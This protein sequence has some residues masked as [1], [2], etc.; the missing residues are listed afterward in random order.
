[1]NLTL[2]TRVALAGALL[3]SATLAQAGT[4]LGATR[5]ILAAPAK[6]TS[7]PIKNKGDEDIMIQSWVE[8]DGDDASQDVPFAITPALSRLGGG[9]QQTLRIFYQGQGLPTNRESVFWLSVQEIPQKA[10]EENTLQIAVR[11]RIKLFYRPAGL[12]GK[13][14]DAPK[15][16]TWRLVDHGVQVSNPTVYHVSLSSTTLRDG[17]REYPLK[18]DMIAPGATT[19]LALKDAGARPSATA[20][21]SFQVVNDFGGIDTLDSVLSR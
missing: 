2:R 18:T 6:E 8:A 11:Q 4:Q 19:V 20:T 1:M 14:A 21:V 5:A 17:A 10:K 16:L 15:A 3:L 12:A 7:I 9:K 13:P